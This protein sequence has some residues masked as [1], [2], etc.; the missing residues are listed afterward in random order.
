MGMRTVTVRGIEIGAGKPKI[1]VPMVGKKEDELLQEAM[2]IRNVPA[3][4][5]EWRIDWFESADDVKSV[6]N[7]AEKIRAALGDMPL[8]ATFRTAHEGGEKEITAES[9]LALNQALARQQIVDLLDVEVYFEKDAVQALIQEAHANGR[10]VIG[11]NHHFDHTPSKEEIVKRL[12]YMQ[13]MG[14]DLP[15]I[16]VM[17]QSRQDV[18]TLLEATVEMTECFAD[19]PIVT[20]SMAG[21]GSIS[22]I[23]GEIFGSA[24][25]FGTVSHASA[26]GQL[27]V[28]TLAGILDAL[29]Q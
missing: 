9:Y 20:M 8:L 12:C 15:K 6:L 3:D 23:C 10:V 16:A 17:P 11:S 14:V 22:R 24:M 28:E 18:L 25:T 26:P 21:M 1:C 19:R 4:I 5:V 13:D 29:H 7:M 27:P 2:Q